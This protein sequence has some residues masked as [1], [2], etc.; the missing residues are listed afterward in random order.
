MLLVDSQADERIDQLAFLFAQLLTPDLPEFLSLGDVVHEVQRPFH[1]GRR[2]RSDHSLFDHLQMN[3]LARETGMHVNQAIDVQG[4]RPA[5]LQHPRLRRFR[6]HGRLQACRLSH[7][8]WD[9]D[10]RC[11]AEVRT[12]RGRGGFRRMVSV[13]A[14]QNEEHAAPGRDPARCELSPRAMPDCRIR[15]S[16]PSHRCGPRCRYEKGLFIQHTA[17]PL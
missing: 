2:R 17:M 12:C 15:A 3:N 9:V 5:Q 6:N 14:C 8:R 4:E 16:V 11:I 1:F 10:G 13:A 7:P